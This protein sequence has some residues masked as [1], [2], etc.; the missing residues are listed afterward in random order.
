MGPLVEKLEHDFEGLNFA[1]LNVHD[2][3]QL[4]LKFQV[5]G[6][7]QLLVFANGEFKGR[8]MHQNEKQ[9]RASFERLIK[10]NG[11]TTKFDLPEALKQQNLFGDP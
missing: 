10:N 2:Y 1:K 11:K 5:R 7:P 9:L 8:I 4:Q 6:V 3:P